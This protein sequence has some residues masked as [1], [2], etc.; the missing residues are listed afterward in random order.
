MICCQFIFK[1]GTY[2]DDFHHLDGQIDKYARSLP[3]FVKSETWH[4][5]ETGMVNAIYYFSD[6]KSVA[7]LARFPRHREAKGQVKRWYEGYRI[8]VSQVEATYGDGRLPE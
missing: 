4:S 3:G 8:V 6:Q 1:P 5:A 2:D 7:Q